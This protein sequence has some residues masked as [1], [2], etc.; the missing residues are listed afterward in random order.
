METV[1]AK[2]CFFLQF[3]FAIAFLFSL[4]RE[5]WKNEKKEKTFNF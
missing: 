2:K 3:F 1:Q 4:S 5:K